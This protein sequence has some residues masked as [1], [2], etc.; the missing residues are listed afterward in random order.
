MISAL[1]VLTSNCFLI[2]IL[3]VLLRVQ[4]PEGTKRIEVPTKC[5]LYDLYSEVRK[6]VELI[7]VPFV[8]FAE[9]NFTKEVIFTERCNFKYCLI[10]FFR[11][12]LHLVDL[13]R[14]AILN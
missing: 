2:V 4:S 7:D 11:F 8:L 1:C 10:H 3:Q 6:N 5:T 9:R 13:K 12:R 14:L